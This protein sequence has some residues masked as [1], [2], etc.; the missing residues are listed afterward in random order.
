MTRRL[1]IEWTRGEKVTGLL[2]MPEAGAATGILLAHG[3][4]APQRHP[5]LAGLRRDLAH[6]GLAVLTFDYA[7]AEAGRKAP[8]RL[9]KLLAVHRAAADR[10]AAYCDRVVLAGKSMGGRVA[11]HLAGDAGWDAAALI[12]YGYPLVPMGKHEPRDTSHL[13]RITVP[14]LFFAGSRDRLGPPDLI[15]RVA[16]GLPAAAVIEVTAGDHSFRIPKR[17]G[18]TAAQVLERIAA[19]SAAWIEDQIA[20][21][22]RQPRPS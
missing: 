12:Y 19:D 10:L 13:R 11:S 8:D 7:Y 14:Q 2:A 17:S 21:G 6:H 9:E 3:A 5:F 22:R 16:A 18:L 4:G 1:R 15:R 20:T